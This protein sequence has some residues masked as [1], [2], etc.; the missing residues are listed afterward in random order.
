MNE[1]DK[2]RSSSWNGFLGDQFGDWMASTAHT[3]TRA[4]HLIQLT[5]LLLSQSLP[6]FNSAD[7]M[8]S[9]HLRGI[10][11]ISPHIWHMMTQATTLSTL[12]SIAGICLLLLSLE[13]FL[14]FRKRVTC[15]ASRW[16]YDS[17]IN[18]FERE[19][20]T[21]RWFQECEE[22]GQNAIKKYG[23]ICWHHCNSDPLLYSKLI[24]L[25]SFILLEN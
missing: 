6:D 15:K 3:A 2:T 12:R 23:T 7:G 4:L 18:Y 25:N 24:N 21:L 8:N 14:H 9:S 13:M 5:S 20:I 19:S 10:C 1:I 11:S 17:F 22:G 16:G